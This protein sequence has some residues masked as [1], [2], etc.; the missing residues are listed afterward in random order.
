MTKRKDAEIEFAG[1]AVEADHAGNG[2]YGAAEWL[3]A[4]LAH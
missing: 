1:S 4:A 2:G 3:R